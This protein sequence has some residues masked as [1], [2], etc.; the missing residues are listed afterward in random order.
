MIHT[1]NSHSRQILLLILSVWALCL[2]LHPLCAQQST[3]GTCRG[4][5]TD[6]ENGRPLEGVLVRDA[7]G[8]HGAV[9]DATGRYAITLPP[10]RALLTFSYLGYLSQTLPITVGRQGTMQRDV[11]LHPD[12]S[13]LSEVI[14]TG[15][16]AA[17]RH[18]EAPAAITVV[19]ASALRYHMATLNELLN[20]TAGIQVAR[21]GGMGSMARILVQGLDGKRIG[22]FINGMPV[23]NSE[24][25]SLASIP[26]D[27]V[28]EVEIYKGIVPARLGGD[29]LGGAVNI[30][31]KDFQNDHLE[32]SYSIGS[33]HTHSAHLQ[34]KKYVPSL[35]VALRTG[36]T[37]DY[38]KNDYS[39][40][41]PFEP[42]RIIRR[43]HDAYRR[44][45]GEL[46]ISFTRLPLD[47]AELSFGYENLYDE[48]QGGLMNV[49]NNIRHAFSRCNTLSIAQTISKRLC[50]DRLS[51]MLSASQSFTTANQVDTSHYSYDFLGNRFL[52][53]SVQGEVGSLPND[54]RDRYTHMQERL[55]ANYRFSEVHAL[56]ANVTHRYSRKMPK[57]DLAD[58]YSRFPTGGYPS[59]LHSLVAG[60]TYEMRLAEGRFVNEVG[61]KFFHY[62]AEVMPSPERIVLQDKLRAAKSTKSAPGWSEA[63]AF[64]PNDALTV[65]ASIQSLRR[66]PTSDEMFGNGVLIYPS[67]MLRPEQSLNLNLGAGWI[68]RLGRY[69]HA[70]IEVNAFYMHL[71]DMIKMM[72]G[73][74][75]MAYENIGRA[76][77]TGV[78]GS[79]DAG[80]LPWLDFR[81]N[82]AW[83]DA[84][85]IRKDAVGGGPN[86][87]YNYRIPN[88]PYF[89]G[90]CEVNLH[91][92]D[93]IGRKS[94]SALTLGLEFTH[95]FSYNWEE[96]GSRSAMEIPSKYEVHLGVHHDFNSR[97]QLGLE[98]RNLFD[99]ENWAEYRYPLEKRTLHLKVKYVLNERIGS[100]KQ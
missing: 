37:F 39:F 68:V 26:P 16:S 3:F 8:R 70:R 1:K 11:I 30:L 38:S 28:Q 73:A 84:R 19:D 40:N 31:L 63:I 55:N 71:S 81:G 33:Y 79:V 91:S 25:F 12:S 88:T 17:Q 42:G 50:A 95:R 60:L 48:I 7:E 100:K 34:A 24:E 98:V 59:L 35:G 66:M 78:E 74:M 96:P 14:V 89:F 4:T 6:A 77:I 15:K 83:Q 93:L 54:S 85:D 61:L 43:D 82:V 65:K 44:I 21:R 56:N 23:G 67:Y 9:T 90:N 69:P 52:S 92:D 27:M 2:S 94:H 49:Q 75:Y 29:G 18:R 57:D 87:H 72:Y 36:G 47:N 64:H 10:G 99:R 20:K 51:L 86:F 80:L 22:I 97:W 46:G 62:H 53:S 32:A 5:V 76:R 45:S 58:S 13:R 41:S